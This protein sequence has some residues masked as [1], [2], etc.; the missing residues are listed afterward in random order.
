MSEFLSAWCDL[1]LLGS[2]QNLPLLLVALLLDRVFVRLAWVAPRRVV[3]ALVVME[4]N[5]MPIGEENTQVISFTYTRA[6]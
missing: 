3:W 4:L 2:V 5:D 6:K 1:L